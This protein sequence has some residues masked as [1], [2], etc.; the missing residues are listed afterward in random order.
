ML[1]RVP[2][3]PTWALLCS[4]G[5]HDREG[6]LRRRRRRVR[7]RSRRIAALLGPCA[8]RP[9]RTAAVGS[10]AHSRPS[11][12]VRYSF[13]V[14]KSRFRSSRSDDNDPES[15]T[16][17]AR[18]EE[19]YG[20][21]LRTANVTSPVPVKSLHYRY[22]HAVYRFTGPTGIFFPPRIAR[23]IFENAAKR[24]GEKVRGP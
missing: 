9:I 23:N 6:G 19:A 18:K 12:S 16:R 14:Q 21:S 13:G 7:I 17:I 22:T 4:P 5:G 20:R 3:N 24:A 15:T 11:S 1:Y 10:R 2:T 8:I